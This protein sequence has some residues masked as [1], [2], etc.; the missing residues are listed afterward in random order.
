MC[1]EERQEQVAADKETRRVGRENHQKA[2]KDWEKREGD[3]KAR[4]EAKR[5]AWK[6]RVAK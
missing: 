2:V 3:R 4:N 6:E 5:V 1:Q